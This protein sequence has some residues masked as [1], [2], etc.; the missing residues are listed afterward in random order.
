MAL[1]RSVSLR[2]ADER[3]RASTASPYMRGKMSPPVS[4]LAATR[5]ERLQVIKQARKQENKSSS[6]RAIKPAGAVVS[7]HAN[8]IAM[9][10]R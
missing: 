9:R 7:Y 3:R 4:L 5:A 6:Y 8:K 2:A 1:A 10:T